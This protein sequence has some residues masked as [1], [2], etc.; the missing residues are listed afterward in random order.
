MGK[1]MQQLAYGCIFM[2]SKNQL[3]PGPNFGAMPPSTQETPQPSDIGF[4]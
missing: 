2:G 1:T 4:K 3:F